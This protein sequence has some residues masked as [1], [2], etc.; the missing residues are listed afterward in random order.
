MRRNARQLRGRFRLN[1]LPFAASG[2][3]AAP[4]KSIPLG[5][6]RTYQELQVKEQDYGESKG[7]ETQ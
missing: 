2:L 5:N 4:L 3:G 1:A 7:K 6:E